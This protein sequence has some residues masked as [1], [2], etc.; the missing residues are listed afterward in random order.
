MTLPEAGCSSFL[1]GSECAI[2][3]MVIP[4]RRRRL[5]ANDYE[6][7]TPGDDEAH[8]KQSENN[9]ECRGSAQSEEPAK[10]SSNHAS[11]HRVILVHGLVN[12]ITPSLEVH[13][14]LPKFVWDRE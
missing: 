5:K 3:R 9:R 8:K 4:A 10:P 2:H 12:P 7:Q 14:E 13:A 6:L 1:I 11:K